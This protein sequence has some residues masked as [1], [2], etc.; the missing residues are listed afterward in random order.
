MEHWMKFDTNDIFEISYESLLKNPEKNVSEMLSFL[1]I[2]WED[3]CLKF[4]ENKRT[5]ST[6]SYTQ[7]RQPLYKSSMRR[8]RN[9]L[10][11]IPELRDSINEKYILD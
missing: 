8:W 2:S 1:D 9:Y 4:Y 5:V 10:S 7:V 11:H 3:D 6:P